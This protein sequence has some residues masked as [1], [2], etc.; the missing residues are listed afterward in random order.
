MTMPLRNYLAALLAVFTAS[1][2]TQGVEVRTEPLI[3][4]NGGFAAVHIE[5]TWAETADVGPLAGAFEPSPVATGVDAVF[6][7]YHGVDPDEV[8]ELL[9]WPS[10]SD[11]LAGCRLGATESAEALPFDAVVDLLDVGPI[12]VDLAGEAIVVEDRLFPS[13]HSLLAGTIYAD[14][15]SA[16]PA[17]LEAAEYRL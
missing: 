13:V 15:L 1:C 4:G 11:G 5:R 9:G 7:Q 8:L 14:E 16:P 6:A 10:R 2:T 12:H 17:R 3:L